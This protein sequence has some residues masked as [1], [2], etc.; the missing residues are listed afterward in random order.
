MHCGRR[1][2]GVGNKYTG[3]RP[4]GRWLV[5]YIVEAKQVKYRSPNSWD[6]T[7]SSDVFINRISA[8]FPDILSFEQPEDVNCLYVKLDSQQVSPSIPMTKIWR[9]CG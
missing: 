1:S 6:V 3:V 9:T 5:V 8:L 7:L 4:K 2:R